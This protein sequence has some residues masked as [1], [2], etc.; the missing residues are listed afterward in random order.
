MDDEINKDE[1][2][3]F[4]D[5][6]MQNGK[7]YDRTLAD[8]IFSIFDTDKSGKISVDEFIKTFIHIEEE[9]KTHKTQI[10]AK[11][12]AEKDKMEDIQKKVNY[13]RS[14]K[15]NSE[16]IAPSAKLTCEI[17]NIEFLRKKSNSYIK[18][19]LSFEDI[20]ESTKPI[21]NTNSVI[22]WNQKFEFKPTTRSPLIFD[23]IDVDSNTSEEIIIGSVQF[24]LEN[25][26]KQEDYDVTL[27]IPDDE[28]S[29]QSAISCK[30]N[31]KISFIWSYFD[32]YSELLV[33]AEKNVKSYKML[34]EKNNGLLDSLNGK[35]NNI[36]NILI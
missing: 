23:I 24:D 1:M 26:D 7:Q 3:Q 28:A 17:T 14:E 27:E 36:Y 8:K 29:S 19:R 20:T 31:C 4:F 35:Y 25:I 11:Y 6:N 15:L 33:K 18:I 21:L 5:S 16:G 13:Y 22:Y 30:I 2:L 32:Y 12:Q 9:L 34:L 10:K